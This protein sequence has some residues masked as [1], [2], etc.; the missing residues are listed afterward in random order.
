MRIFDD[1]DN[2]L[3]PGTAGEIV[4]RPRKPNVMFSGYWRRPEATARDSRN[5][6]WH[7]GDIG[8]ID[9]D[10][11]LFFVDRKADY[12]RRRGENISTWELEKTFHEHPQVADVAVIGVPSPVGE[13]DVKLTV[14]LQPDATITAEELC[15]WSFDRVPHFAV[16]RYIEFRT[17][18]PRSPTGRITKGPLR[19]DGITPATWDREAAGIAVP[20]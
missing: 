16:P 15:R 4:V 6:W 2:E 13:D 8:R 14:V 7:T 5:L 17:D 10:G 19:E 18:L 3:P 12:I 20:R 11:Y 1:D 9:G